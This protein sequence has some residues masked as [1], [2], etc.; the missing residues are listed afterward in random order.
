MRWRN[1]LHQPIQC[2]VLTLRYKVWWQWNQH[3]WIAKPAGRDGDRP[4]QRPRLDSPRCWRSIGL[5]QCL[6]AIDDDAGPYPCHGRV[7]GSARVARRHADGRGI[8]GR[9]FRRDYIRASG[10]ASYADGSECRVSIQRRQPT[11]QQ[12]HAQSGCVLY[13]RHYRGLSGTQ[14]GNAALTGKMPF[15]ECLREGMRAATTSPCA[16]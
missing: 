4:R 10:G 1:R 13:R 2:A 11:A 8:L 15:R 3:I 9:K 6:F 12:C 5:D 14:L 7:H 16:V